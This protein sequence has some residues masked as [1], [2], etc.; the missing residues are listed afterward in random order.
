MARAPIY[1]FIGLVV[2]LILYFLSLVIGLLSRYREEEAGLLRSRGGSILQ[3]GGLLIA[4]EGIVTL[5]AIAIGPFLA[6]AIVRYLLINTIDPVGAGESGIPVGISADM[7]VMG[8]VGGLL[9][10]M[11]LVA[12]GFNRARLGMVATLRS[13]ARPPTVPLL[14]RYY[15]DVLVVAALGLLWWQI[16]SR[17]G[18]VS[19]DVADKALE[20]NPT[21]LFGPVLVLLAVAFIILRVLPVLVNTLAWVMS[22]VSPALG[23]FLHGTGWPE[24]LCPMAP[25][26]SS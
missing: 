5:L 18:F 1:L 17:G 16:S 6:L 19:R 21:L 7:F 20:V 2:L 14:H 11:V 26:L 9:S 3:I 23:R 24:T 25:W 10:L 22:R 12:N 15:V 8:A 4:A 13:R